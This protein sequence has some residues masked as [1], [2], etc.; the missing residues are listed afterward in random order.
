MRKFAQTATDKRVILQRGTGK[1]HNQ[2]KRKEKHV[3]FG[4]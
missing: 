2:D 4:S 3:A 1:G